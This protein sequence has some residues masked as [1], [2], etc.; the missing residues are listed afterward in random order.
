[1]KS[2]RKKAKETILKNPEL[3]T[4]TN[5]AVFLS[6]LNDINQEEIINSLNLTSSQPQSN[7]MA[8][9]IKPFDEN[10][11]NH[12]IFPLKRKLLSSVEKPKKKRSPL[13]ALPLNLKEQILSE[14]KLNNIESEESLARV[15]KWIKPS[16]QNESNDLKSAIEK[17]I[18][19]MR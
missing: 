14:C 9:T 12:S 16:V 13:K 18:D 8:E 19:E 4:D 2:I 17:R 10:I 1:M 15:S 7:K 11:Q 6:L 5:R 3:N